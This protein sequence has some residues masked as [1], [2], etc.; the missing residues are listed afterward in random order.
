MVHPAESG[1]PGDRTA[2]HPSALDRTSTWHGLVR[3]SAELQEIGGHIHLIKTYGPVFW[4][5]SAYSYALLFIGLLSVIQFVTHTSEIFRRQ[6]I[7]ILLGILCPLIGNLLYLMRLTPFPQLD[8]T[9]FSFVVMGVAGAWGMFRYGFLDIVPFARG[10]VVDEMTDGVLVAN[11]DDTIVD[12]NPSA[13]SFLGMSA[14]DCIGRR[15]AECIPELEEFHIGDVKEVVRGDEAEP[16]AFE[17]Q[18]TP[19]VD[20]RE[21]IWGSVILIHDITLR[22]RS[23]EEHIRTQRL[24]AIGEFSAGISH[25]LTTS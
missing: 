5:H 20:A 4:V 8:L 21:Q 1:P 14:D 10:T 12:L 25:N 2:R 19:L 3:S 18:R 15:T 13:L 23:E 17:V 9:P 22:K 16:R 11:K 7:V 6:G 24:R